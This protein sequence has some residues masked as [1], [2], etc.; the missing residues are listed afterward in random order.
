MN[1]SV[2][3][4]MPPFKP[5]QWTGWISLVIQVV[6]RMDQDSMDNSGELTRESVAIVNPDSDEQ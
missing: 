1:A 3:K 2:E 5:Q 6:V 4:I